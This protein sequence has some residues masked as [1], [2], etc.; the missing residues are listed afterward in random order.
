MTTQQSHTFS[1]FHHRM[2]H[3]F[4]YITS[5][6]TLSFVCMFRV[7][8]NHILVYNQRLSFHM[9]R[10]VPNVLRTAVLKMRFHKMFETIVGRPWGGANACTCKCKSN[11]TVLHNPLINIMQSKTHN[12][13]HHQG[14]SGSGAFRATAMG[15]RAFCCISSCCWPSGH[16][17]QNRR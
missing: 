10:G 17:L 13:N 5:N 1:E 8:C 4:N 9:H 6:T 14:C 11:D 12:F 2:M 15:S 16:A 7:H 3:I